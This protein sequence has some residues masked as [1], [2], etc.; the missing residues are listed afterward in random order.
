MNASCRAKLGGF[1][2]DSAVTYGE[3]LV[4]SG[5]AG[6]YRRLND[7]P[8]TSPLPSSTHTGGG[9]RPGITGENA[10]VSLFKE[11]PEIL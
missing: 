4:F 7:L 3:F 5:I 9:G 10:I 6:L 2:A 8:D 11:P 1:K